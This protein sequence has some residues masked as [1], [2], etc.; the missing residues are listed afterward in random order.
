MK[1]LK[2]SYF[3]IFKVATELVESAYLFLK[4]NESAQE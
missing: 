4:N 2:N 3:S 1:G